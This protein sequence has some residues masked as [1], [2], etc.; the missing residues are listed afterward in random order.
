MKYFIWKCDLIIENICIHTGAGFFPGFSSTVCCQNHNFLLSPSTFCYQNHHFCYHHQRFVIIT[1]TSYRWYDLHDKQG[2]KWLSFNK[3]NWNLHFHVH[4]FM[5]KE[6]TNTPSPYRKV[7]FLKN[8]L[9][10]NTLSKNLEKKNSNP[11]QHTWLCVGGINQYPSPLLMVGL[12]A[13]R[14]GYWRSGTGVEY[15]DH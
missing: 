9:L 6:S 2:K 1:I 15:F 4:D 10:R 11:H 7:L 12:K 8:A 14:K 3:W 13:R 5:F